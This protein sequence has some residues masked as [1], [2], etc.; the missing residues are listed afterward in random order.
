MP[1]IIFTFTVNTET[2]EANFSGNIQ[3]RVALQFLQDIVISEA[4]RQAKEETTKKVEGN[5]EVQHDPVS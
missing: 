3:P 4:V 2:Q 5:K 1:Q